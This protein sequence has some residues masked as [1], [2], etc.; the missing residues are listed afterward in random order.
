MSQALHMHLEFFCAHISQP[1]GAGGP[2]EEGPG[3][4][5]QN[6]GPHGQGRAAHLHPQACSLRWADQTGSDQHILSYCDGSK[7]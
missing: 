6:Q 3:L 4:A 2:D 7:Q 5:L 1:P